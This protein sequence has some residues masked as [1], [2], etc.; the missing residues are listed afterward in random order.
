MATSFYSAPS[1]M[2]GGYIVNSGYRRQRG[3]GVFASMR[4][5]MAPIGRQALSGIKSIARNKTVQG[6]AKKAAAKGAE[7]LTG[8]AVDALQERDIGQSFKERGRDVAL[9]TLTGEPA[10]TPANEASSGSRKR[11]AR[12]KSVRKTPAKKLKQNKKRMPPAKIALKEPP[13]KKKR[14]LSRAAL[15]RGRLF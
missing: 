10:N 13:R 4:K 12:S 2:A 8:V 15:N 14:V 11:K 9:R 3:A 7:V 5:Y 6:I 1:H